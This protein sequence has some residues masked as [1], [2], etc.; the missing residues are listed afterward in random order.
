MK[1]EK[2]RGTRSRSQSESAKAIGG[3]R[4]KWGAP[5]GTTPAQANLLSHSRGCSVTPVSWPD[6]D[7]ESLARSLERAR[8]RARARTR[9]RP[10]CSAR[11]RPAAVRLF[12]PPTGINRARVARSARARLGSSARL[13]PYAYTYVA[14]GYDDDDE[15]D[16]NDDED[17]CYCCSLGRAPGTSAMVL[18]FSYLARALLTDALPLSHSLSL[19]SPLLSFSVIRV[20]CLA[21][22]R[23]R[24]KFQRDAPRRHSFH[25]FSR[26]RRRAARRRRR[27]A[28]T[29]TPLTR[30][31]YIVPLSL[32][33][34]PSPS[35]SLRDSS[36]SSWIVSV[37]ERR[38]P[39]SARWNASSHSNRHTTGKRA[40]RTPQWQVGRMAD[41]TSYIF[42]LLFVRYHETRIPWILD[43]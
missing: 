14:D 7:S 28:R 2:E 37:H 4:G 42:Y 43:I 34:P 6:P 29:S 36:P 20:K 30:W 22:A 31:G 9:D 11:L 18:T 8:A 32:F 27:T 15:D 38:T 24:R 16:D 12:S 19:F 21:S 33:L 3:E 23:K 41:P 26:R 40:R 13:S 25:F 35:A 39:Y 1:E 17:A 10:L 5:R